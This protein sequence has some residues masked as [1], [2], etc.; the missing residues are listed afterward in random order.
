MIGRRGSAERSAPPSAARA[1][2]LAEDTGY[3]QHD[4][5][6]LV[7]LE[8]WDKEEGIDLA[9]LDPLFVEICRRV[10][11]ARDAD[12]TLLALGRPSDC[13]RVAVSKETKGNLGDP[14]TPIADHAALTVA[15]AGF[16]YRLLY[17][18]LATD[19]FE[20]PASLKPLVDD[21][22]DLWLHAAVLVRGQ[23]KTEDLHERWERVPKDQGAWEKAGAIGEQMIKDG[24]AAKTA[25]HLGVVSFLQ[26]GPERADL[27]DN[28]GDP[29]LERFEQAVDA[30]FLPHLFARVRAG[31]GSET[32]R[33]WNDDLVAAV[34][35]VF[36][37]ATAELQPPR[38]RRERANAIATIRFR[39]ALR[40]AGLAETRISPAI[41][42][43]PETAGAF[44]RHCTP[45][46][47]LR[48]ARGNVLWRP[49]RASA[50]G[51]D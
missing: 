27:R 36:N 17:R 25:L 51:P 41:E 47:T 35:R 14:W 3:Y 43:P 42:E 20:R 16:D 33:A 9:D 11:L 19:E 2:A 23:G 31:R 45:H 50:H 1:R 46:R 8:P 15:A 49:C 48:R 18:L 22:E 34:T 21:P 13:A 39:G 29:Y 40:R 44:I 26:G 32:D 30:I 24:R 7:W 38:T 10:R 28:R 6:P 12:G 5:L 37:A 4:G